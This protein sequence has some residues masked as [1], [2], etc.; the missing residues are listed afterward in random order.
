MRNAP[1][2]HKS[3]AASGA[4]T[5]HITGRVSRHYIMNHQ[6]RHA[7]SHHESPVTPLT[8]TSQITRGRQ[9]CD[10]RRRCQRLPKTGDRYFSNLLS[11]VIQKRPSL[12]NEDNR[13]WKI[14]H[15]NRG[16]HPET[17]LRSFSANNQS[18]DLPPPVEIIQGALI[19]EHPGTLGVPI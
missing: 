15:F 17:D 10:F 16:S 12:K 14:A 19:P 1:S 8:I 7:L 11:P 3:P 4:I 13:R 5:S 9:R 2:H 18:L 6:S